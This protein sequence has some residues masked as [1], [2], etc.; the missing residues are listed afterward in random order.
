MPIVEG[1]WATAADATELTGAVPS[2][3]NMALAQVQIEDAIR[4]VYR[5]DDA[6]RSEYRWLRI[7]V[8]F[9]GAYVA[10]NPDLFAQAEISATGQDGWSVTFRDGQTSR[11]YAPEA[12]AA[13]D[14]LPGSSNVTIRLNSAFQPRGRRRRAMWRPY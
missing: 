3:A 5:A 10:D 6:E 8:A 13:L 9:Q 1:T 7:A 14:N 11:R 2:A 12:M 4:R